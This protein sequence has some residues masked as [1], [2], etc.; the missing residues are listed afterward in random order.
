MKKSDKILCGILLVFGLFFIGKTIYNAKVEK[1]IACHELYGQVKALQSELEKKQAVIDSLQ[2]NCWNL[3]DYYCTAENLLDTIFINFMEK[4]IF[5]FE[6]EP[7]SNVVNN[8]Y[9]NNNSLY[10]FLELRRS[11]Y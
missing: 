4:G 5:V 6:Y 9:I 11:T 3:E 10:S 1:N 7:Y 2:I 8:I